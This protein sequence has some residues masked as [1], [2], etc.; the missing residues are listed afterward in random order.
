MSKPRPRQSMPPGL[1]SQIAFAVLLTA[2]AIIVLPSALSAGRTIE[3]EPSTPT[4][5]S[6]T[7]SQ[8]TFVTESFSAAAFTDWEQDRS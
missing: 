6:V 1:K 8:R 7:T 3:I 5:G 4:A 2:A